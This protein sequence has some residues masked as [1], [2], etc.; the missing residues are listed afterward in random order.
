MTPAE[1]GVSTLVLDNIQLKSWCARNCVQRKK[2]LECTVYE[3]DG[4]FSLS[5]QDKVVLRI[6]FSKYR[7]E[8][9]ETTDIALI[10]V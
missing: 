2:L 5:Y 9:E 1:P 3:G 8:I 10:K 7:T 4:C 6:R